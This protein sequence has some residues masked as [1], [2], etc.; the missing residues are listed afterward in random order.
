MDGKKI[1][2]SFLCGAGGGMMGFCVNRLNTPSGAVLFALGAAIL[3]FSMIRL[4]K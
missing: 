4:R 3:A 2:L 1:F